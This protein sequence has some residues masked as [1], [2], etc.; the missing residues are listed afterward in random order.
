L[1]GGSLAVGLK[2]S[3]HRIPIVV[4]ETVEFLRKG[5][6][7]SEN[8]FRAN[9]NID[10]ILLLKTEYERAHQ[11]STGEEPASGIELASV[12]D[13]AA[14]LKLYLRELKTS[15]IPFTVYQSFIN[16]E[17]RMSDN[18]TKVTRYHALESSV[19]IEMRYVLVYVLQF[20][21]ECSLHANKSAMDVKTL[22]TV[23]ASIL[24]RP[25][26]ENTMTNNDLPLRAACLTVLIPN[27]ESVFSKEEKKEET[28]ERVSLFNHIL[29]QIR[30]G[31]K[32]RKL[33]AKEIKKSKSVE[34]KSSKDHVLYQIRKGKALKPA[35]KKRPPLFGG[36]LEEALVSSPLCVPLLVYECVEYMRRT[37]MHVM[38][39][40]RISGNNDTILHIKTLF[41]KAHSIASET[42]QGT[43]VELTD[44]HE[45]ASVLKLYL[46]ELPDPLIPFSFYSS[47][48]E[49][50]ETKSEDLDAKITKYKALIARLPASHRALLAYLI[51]FLA[52][53]T[54]YEKETKMDAQNFAI[55]FAPSLFRP[56]CDSPKTLR[57]M[58]H[59]IDCLKTF[60]VQSSIIFPTPLAGDALKRSDT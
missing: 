47:F 37:A 45:A 43:G 4:Y 56:Q 52:A 14:L 41:E 22:A 51:Q 5:G 59:S 29:T 9:G 26:S 30:V 31:K 6:M 53:C 10:Q 21:H 28:K 24:L 36:P 34:S 16:V 18:E 35:L 13:A 57:D 19:P 23:F 54:Q 44:P 50:E 11:R 55:V 27:A 3:P 2:S 32:L 7:E 49:I 25:Q 17:E 42:D 33:A 58:P 39:I 60:I 38:G 40:F 8:L 20:L 48:I 12:Y 46:R 15:L 1:F